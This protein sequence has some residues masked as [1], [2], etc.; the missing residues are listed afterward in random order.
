MA[1]TLRITL[2]CFKKVGLVLSRVKSEP[3]QNIYPEA[4]AASK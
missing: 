1:A 4:V 3:L 2:A